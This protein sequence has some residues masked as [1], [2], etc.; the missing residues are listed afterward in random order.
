M[1][2]I[3]KLVKE[4]IFFERNRV[5]RIYLGGSAY[6]DFLGDKK[7]DSLFPEEWIASKVKAINPKYFT[8]RDGVSIIKDTDI[9]FDD[10]LAK[11]PN[12]LLGN[13]EYDCLVKYLDS[14]I[15]LPFQVH[16][17]KEFSRKHFNSNYGKTEAWLVIAA[18]PNAKIYFGFKNKINKDILSDFEE[19]SLK[20]KN[21][22]ES[23]LSSVDAKVGDVYII[24]AGLAHAIGAGCTII[25][26]QE[27]TD[28]TIQPENWCGDYHITENEKYI[29]L[30]KSTA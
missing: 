25:E 24:K 18:R 9:Y 8:K 21:I 23:V 30:D 20:E 10:L 19:K 22:M 26:V 16:P 17:T 5:Y 27:P 3:E 28:F 11:Y 1:K 2:T 15:R 7:E 12:E 13:R 29:G 14:S 6:H 4:P